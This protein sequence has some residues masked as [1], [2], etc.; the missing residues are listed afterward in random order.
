MEN[1]RPTA[2]P[3]DRGHSKRRCRALS[4]LG[5][6]QV[7]GVV[8]TAGFQERREIRPDRRRVAKVCRTPD[9]RKP[10]AAPLLSR[11]LRPLVP[12]LSECRLDFIRDKKH[13]QRGSDRL[14]QQHYLPAAL[15]ASAWETELHHF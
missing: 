14:D 13:R 4:G 3:A 6:F 12:G 10:A 11:T 8:S 7:E 9:R 5:T 1:H 2:L 15:S